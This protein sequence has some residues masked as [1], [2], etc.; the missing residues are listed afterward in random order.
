MKERI[1]RLC[2]RLDK[3]SFE[4][5]T[6]I[7]DD[8]DESVLELA[9][10]YLIDEKKITKKGDLYFYNKDLS[11]NSIRGRLPQ[12]FQH[13]S[14]QEIDLIIKGFCAD[15]EVLKMINLL[16]VSNK[17]INNF[18]QYFRTMIYEEQM[19]ELSMCFEKH[20]KIAQER[21][22][23]NTK[24]Y[25]YLYNN[26]LFVSEKYLTSKD[27]I[28]HTNEERLEIKK[29]YLRS[30]RKVLSHTYAYRFHLH[31]AE[32]L[33][34]YGKGFKDLFFK[35]NKCCMVKNLDIADVFKI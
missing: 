14:K 25:L 3:F 26:K 4:D 12:F 27:A 20:P 21:V 13:H 23:M 5:I 18:Y 7:A 16:G 15:V 29:I 9:L 33:W 17:V 31:V 6:T 8:I 2:K 22:Y 35:L 1:L 11:L 19:K 32:E 30:Y 10:I 28:K 24:V 34:K